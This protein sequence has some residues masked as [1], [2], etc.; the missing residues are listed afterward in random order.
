MHWL[1]SKQVISLQLKIKSLGIIR[2]KDANEL[3]VEQEQAGVYTRIAIRDSA[4]D[5]S[6]NSRI[7]WYS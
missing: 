4:I 5:D 7:T 1:S 2:R 6:L 3:P